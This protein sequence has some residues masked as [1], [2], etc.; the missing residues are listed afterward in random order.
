MGLRRMSVEKGNICKIEFVEN[1]CTNYS[2]AYVLRSYKNI[3]NY[4][5]I[6]TLDKQ[7]DDEYKIRID[8]EVKIN[9]NKCYVLVNQIKTIDGFKISAKLGIVSEITK[10]LID[11][12]L[13]EYLG[14]N[15]NI[16]EQDN[17]EIKIIKPNNRRLTDEEKLDLINNYTNTKKLYYANKYNIPIDKIG[18]KVASLRCRYK[19]SK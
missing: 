11:N 19:K 17:I 18:Q 14:F 15:E 10:E 12:K 2:Y 5:V 8:N 7:E 6:N 16:T 4:L 9:K 3:V 1:M 13:K